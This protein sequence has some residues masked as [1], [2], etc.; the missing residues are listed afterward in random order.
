MLA[1]ITLK[2]TTY[3]LLTENGFSASNGLPL[4]NEFP[5]VQIGT[6]DLTD[7]STK[8]TSS[9]DF[10]ATFHVWEWVSK[11]LEF[12]EM[13]SNVH[14]LLLGNFVLDNANFTLE[15]SSLELVTILND[16]LN[17]EPVLHGVLQIKYTISNE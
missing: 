1:T 6:V 17:N 4:N 8:N 9:N 14:D 10:V 12:Y 7:S 11:E 15:N 5:Y 16:S 3:S 13:L 2:T